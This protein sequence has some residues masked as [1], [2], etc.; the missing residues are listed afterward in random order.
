MVCRSSNLYGSRLFV[1]FS[2]DE[3]NFN[4]IFWRRV[5]GELMEHDDWNRVSA[6]ALHM[7]IGED[8]QEML[9]WSTKPMRRQ[10]LNCP[11]DRG[12]DWKIICDTNL[13]HIQPGH[14]EGEI[15]QL[16]SSMAILHFQPKKNYRS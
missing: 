6:V 15:L 5:D 4:R 3:R 11:H 10:G 9:Y 2:G 7:G 16:P 8:E 12:Q 14:A 1:P 13:S